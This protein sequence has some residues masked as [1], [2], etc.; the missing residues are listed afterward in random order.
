MSYNNTPPT[1]FLGDPVSIHLSPNIRSTSPVPSS[2][3]LRTNPIQYP[4]SPPTSSMT[5]QPSNYSIQQEL[6]TLSTL[7][8][9]PSE[10][11]DK[12]ASLLL[13]LATYIN[14]SN[15]QHTAILTYVHQSQEK[16]MTEIDQK[17]AALY[18]KETK[19]R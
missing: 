10:Q 12:M 3:T 18:T 16:Q 9:K 7:Y 1:N 11:D 15:Q 13:S 4:T 6:H 19:A 2:P 17:I 14:Q 5:S 8:S